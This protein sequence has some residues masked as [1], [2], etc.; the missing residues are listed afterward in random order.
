MIFEANSF[1]YNTG[2]YVQLIP[3]QLVISSMTAPFK[4]HTH[5]Y[6]KLDLKCM[7]LKITLQA[8]RY[9][10]LEWLGTGVV[11]LGVLATIQA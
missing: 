1:I 3:A 9:V 6:A 2:L 8:I 11:R 10:L 7:L 4:T 5:T